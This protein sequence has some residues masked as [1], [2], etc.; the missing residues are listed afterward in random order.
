M[1]IRTDFVTNSS[2]SSF[3]I[4]KRKVDVELTVEGVFEKI[5]ELY[6]EYDAKLP[7]IVE[8]VKRRYGLTMGDDGRFFDENGKWVH[9]HKTLY[10]DIEERFDVDPH[11]LGE[12]VTLDDYA[13]YADYE[14]EGRRCDDGFIIADFRDKSIPLGDE[15]WEV[16]SWYT[17]LELPCNAP[18]PYRRCDGCCYPDDVC[19]KYELVREMLLQ[20]GEICIHS[21]EGHIP[22]NVVRQL[23]K[24]C[25][26]HCNH[27]G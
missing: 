22:Y 6:R 14:A 10:D 26:Y 2:S 5:K 11:W 7:E 21:W 27:M 1:K 12:I 13:S 15:D 3:I 8:Y 25:T 9:P 24:L 18:S 17:D 16:I 20:L 4:D 19:H 23:E